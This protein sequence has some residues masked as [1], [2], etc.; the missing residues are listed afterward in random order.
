[1]TLRERIELDVESLKQY[2][3]RLFALIQ[4]LSDPTGTPDEE[5][6]VG[7]RTAFVRPDM[8]SN[9][10]S[11]LDFWLKPLADFHKQ[12]ANLPL[13]YRDIRGKND[14]DAYHK[15][16]TKVAGLSLESVAS[17]LSQLD[18]LRKVRNLLIHRGGHVESQEA[19]KL[20]QIPGVSVAGTLILLSDGFIWD[21]LDHASRYLCAVADA[22][23]PSP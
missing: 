10:Y 17:S 15:Y 20:G 12:R 8:A 22:K 7:D 23:V 14:L 1:M 4:E 6:Y 16:F 3:E 5:T 2:F 18:N 9:V 19:S 21:C 11:L 13:S